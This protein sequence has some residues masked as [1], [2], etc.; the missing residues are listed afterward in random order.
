MDN[1]AELAGRLLPVFLFGLL[2]LYFLAQ[3]VS[4]RQPSLRLAN[5][6][7]FCGLAALALPE[8]I[9]GWSPSDHLIVFIISGCLRSLLGIAGVLLGAIAMV[10]RSDGGVGIVRPWVGIAFSLLHLVF[11]AGFLLFSSMYVPSTPWRYQA[12]GGEFRLTLPSKQWQQA[13]TDGKRVV[14]FMCSPPR[15]Q[16]SVLAVHRQRTESQ[17]LQA[18]EMSR[19][20]LERTAG[21]HGQI[22]VHEETNAAGN[23]VSYFTGMDSTPDGKPVFVAYSITWSPTKQTVI[24]VLFEGL[25][26]MLSNT[27]RATEMNLF[28]WSAEK[29]CLSVE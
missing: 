13:S 6:S 11:G 5:I 28:E 25:P 4:A 27:G 24:E 29:I 26:R 16:C 8:V 3:A 12:P 23:R 7:L 10:M 21:Q 9:L 14:A 18:A 15:M 2:A 1:P 22:K 20:Q 19:A 17:F